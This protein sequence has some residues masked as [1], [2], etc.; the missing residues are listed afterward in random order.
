MNI[1]VKQMSKIDYEVYASIKQTAYPGVYA[2][3]DTTRKKIIEHMEKYESAYDMTYI[4]AYKDDELIGGMR[5]YIF[6]MNFHGQSIQATGIGSVAVDLLH[7]KQHVAQALIEFASNRSQELGIP[8]ITLFP[9]N[10]AFY[11]SF[12]YG[13]GVPVHNYHVSPSHFKD[14]KIREGLSYLNPFSF[15]P[16]KECFNTY[17]LNNHGM[18]HKSTMDE[19]RINT[20]SDGRILTFTEDGVVTGYIIFSQRKISKSNVLRQKLTVQEMIYNTPRA[21]HAFSSFFNTQKDQIEYIE[22]HTFDPKFYQ[23]LCGIQHVSNP[24]QFPLISH[25]L[26]DTSLGMMY[27]ALDCAEL[28]EWVEDRVQENLVFNIIY[29]K[30]KSAEQEVESF[31]INPGHLERL[32]LDFTLQSFSSWIMGAVSLET[33]HLQGRLECALPQ[34]LKLLDRKFALD[35]PKCLNTF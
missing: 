19:S 30:G 25:K 33:L 17:V 20:M 5:F 27:M 8:L 21:L 13:Y 10:A 22:L 4:G 31:E 11:H 35:S 16:L 3:D 18:M 9:F 14:F 34:K 7:K 6:D 2:D 28:I 32:E 29:P 15:E 12:G 1:T 24:A 23:F 26:N